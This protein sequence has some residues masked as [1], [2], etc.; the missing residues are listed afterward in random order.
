MEMTTLG[1]RQAKDFFAKEAAVH[2]KKNP[3]HWTYTSG[4]ITAGEFFAMKYGSGE[5]CVVVF[6]IGEDEP[7]NYQNIMKDE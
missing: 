7:L 6:R 5:D 2:F 4:Q 3:N 1:E